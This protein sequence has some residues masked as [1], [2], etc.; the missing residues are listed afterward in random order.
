MPATEE[1]RTQA[2]SATGTKDQ[3]PWRHS[4]TAAIVST[5]LGAKGS[6]AAPEPHQRRAATPRWGTTVLHRAFTQLQ[7]G[8]GWQGPPEVWSNPPAQARPSG[9]GCLGPCPDGFW[10]FSRMEMIYLQGWRQT[11]HTFSERTLNYVSFWYLILDHTQKWLQPTFLNIASPSKKP[12]NC[13]PVD[14]GAEKYKQ[15]ENG[16][17]FI[18][19]KI[20]WRGCLCKQ[21]IPFRNSSSAKKCPKALPTLGNIALIAS[22]LL[23]NKICGDLKYYSVPQWAQTK[24]LRVRKRMDCPFF[25]QPAPA[26]KNK[27]TSGSEDQLY[28]PGLSNFS[29]YIS[30]SSTGKVSSKYFSQQAVILATKL[31]SSTCLKHCSYA[32]TTSIDFPFFFFFWHKTRWRW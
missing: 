10:I 32:H 30:F 31:A 12:W 21:R 14:T 1:L 16:D 27:Q 25:N 15:F 18:S 3:A 11:G 29:T 28:F 13:L 2:S 24:N 26:G 20:L 8:W 6:A 23:L 17:C 7:S 9:D 4:A 22:G 5:A 19:G